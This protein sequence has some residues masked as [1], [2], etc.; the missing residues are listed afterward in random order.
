VLKWAARYEA[1]IMLAVF[2]TIFAGVGL[3]ALSRLQPHAYHWQTNFD[4]ASVPVEKITISGRDKDDIQPVDDPAFGSVTAALARFSP[5]TPVIVVELG[6]TVH[7]YPLSVL[8]RHGIVNDVLAS[9]AI[10]VTFCPL[11]HTPIVYDRAPDGALLR[12]GVSGNLYNSNLIMWDDATESWWMQ[13]SGEAIV[14]E[15]TGTVL[16][17]VPSVVVSLD[18]FQQRYPS[19]R[20]MLGDARHPQINYTRNPY[21]GYDTNPQ[22][23]MFFS[24]ADPRYMATGRVLGVQINGDAVAY[25]FSTLIGLRTLN[26][27][28]G[29]VPI[30]AFWQPG[31]VSVLD[32]ETI[33]Q[34]RDVGMATVYRRELD[35]Y[36]LSFVYESGVFVDEQTGSTWNIFGE[37]TAGPLAGSAL[38]QVNCFPAFWFAW[39]KT[40]PQTRLVTPETVNGQSNLTGR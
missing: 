39:A 17:I 12:F 22:P 24:E 35:G 33:A 40:Y 26:D 15:Y 10:A 4:I 5:E 3:L 7:A 6:D 37:A 11:C 9:R 20:V 29:G 8:L 23:F 21:I 19:G 1:W 34:S 13:F 2:V 38:E 16:D 25:A 14:G 31:A 27:S 32:D 28:V 36:D 30:V 18:A